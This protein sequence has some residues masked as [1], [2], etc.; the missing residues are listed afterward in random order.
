MVTN[1]TFDEIWNERNGFALDYHLERVKESANES[2]KKHHQSIADYLSKKKCIYQKIS[3]DYNLADLR[4]LEF[5]IEGIRY[6]S[7]SCG[8]SQRSP[9]YKT[10]EAIEKLLEDSLL[11]TNIKSVLRQEALFIGR[12]YGL[13]VIDEYAPLNGIL[14]RVFD[15]PKRKRTN[16]LINLLIAMM[17][18]YFEEVTGKPHYPLIESV[19]KKLFP[20]RYKK[21]HGGS[22]R[23]K[24][25]TIHDIRS[26]FDKTYPADRTYRLLKKSFSKP[27]PIS[28]TS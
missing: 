9:A 5:L 7:I 10:I 17:A 6:L 14:R 24:N 27:L 26:Q 13:A 23:G 12:C 28:L 2:E 8:S 21:V 4:F 15:K 20:Q 18:R 11:S 16:P 19:I 25:R 22:K 3:R 1:I